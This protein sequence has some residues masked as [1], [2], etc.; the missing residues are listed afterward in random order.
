M[1]IQSQEKSLRPL[2]VE[3]NLS[4]LLS[5][6]AR[7][8]NVAKALC[9]CVIKRIQDF[10][11]SLSADEEIGCRLVSFGNSTDFYIDSIEYSGPELL[12]FHCQTTEGQ[13]ATLLQHVS[14][15]NILLLKLPKQAAHEQPRRIGFIVEDGDSSQ[16][17]Q[18]EASQ[19]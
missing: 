2:V 13:E 5:T 14:Q 12:V 17:N 11:R 15:T 1:A 18:P 19:T 3:K 6:R 9:E 7:S 4:D 16:I 10:E 8:G